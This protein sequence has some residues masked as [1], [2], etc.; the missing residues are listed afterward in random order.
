MTRALAALCIHMEPAA[1][2]RMFGQIDVDGSGA[3][4]FGEL[5]HFLSAD[6]GDDDILHLAKHGPT[7]TDVRSL[8]GHEREVA[9]GRARPSSS[10]AMRPRHPGGSASTPGLA[11]AAAAGQRG[12][13]GRMA[14]PQSAVG[15]LTGAAGGQIKR[16]GR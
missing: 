11:G 7:R 15:L 9:Q 12:G 2:K 10:P 8:T 16:S 13:G 3:I 5:K 14:R 6:V 4:D 1:V